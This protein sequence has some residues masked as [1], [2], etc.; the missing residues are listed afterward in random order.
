MRIIGRASAVGSWVA[1]LCLTLL[2]CDPGPEQQTE[3]W[4]TL[5]ASEWPD[6]VL[7][8]E[9]HFADT[10]FH[11]LA[12]A[13]LVDLGADTVGA[14]AKHIF[15]VIGD[16]RRLTSIDLGSDFVRWD[17][18]SKR[19]KGAGLAGV[20]LINQNPREP[21]GDFNSLKTRDWLVF[22]LTT[23]PGDVQP[24]RLRS[25]PLKKGDTAYV[26]GRS[27]A[28]RQ[29]AQPTVVPLRIY[30]DVGP[31]YYVQSLE[32]GADPVG[33]SGSPVIDENGHL[34]GIVSGA[35]G[36]LGIVCSLE[37]LIQVIERHHIA[38]SIPQ[39]ASITRALRQSSP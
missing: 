16:H 2:A 14:T 36:K 39:S 7:T 5:P 12:N 3:A 11:D 27:L 18:R 29:N 13:F 1:I 19:V 10:V 34:V 8:N 15:M 22:K 38:G 33:T 9:V 37:Y 31:Y 30:Q 35:A 20:E 32:S 24:L 25:T 4:A 21:I 28:N 26:V 23:T 6:I 17:L